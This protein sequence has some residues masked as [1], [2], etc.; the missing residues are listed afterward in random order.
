M[1]ISFVIPAF[2]EEMYI[3]KCI[4]SVAREIAA[5]GYNAEII[6][7][8][9]ASTDDT[10]A[11]AL[12]FPDIR[13]IDEPHKGVQYARQAGLVAA[14]GE[15]LAYIDADTM[16][17]PGWLNR[18]VA[19]F[20]KNPRLAALSGPYVYYDLPRRQ[21]IL[22]IIFYAVAFTLHSINALLRIGAVVQGGNLAVRRSTL[23]KIGGMDTSIPFYGDD[24]DIACRLVKVGKVK[25]TWKLYVY[26]SGR[27]MAVE[28]LLRTGAV[29]ALNH[30]MTI[31]TGRPITR[32]YRDIRL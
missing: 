21:R 20:E 16:V 19:E 1:N 31:Y 6:V 15:L 23:E 28:G 29:Y 32:R 11:T 26:S 24:T 18:V 3:G 22:T 27:R 17:P 4:E 2:N 12:L 30:L 5:S 7:V 13:V 25:W 14:Q 8:N 10:R 9:N